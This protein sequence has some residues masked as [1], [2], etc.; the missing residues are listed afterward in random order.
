MQV[1]FL[2][3][4]NFAFRSLVVVVLK[5]IIRVPE[6]RAANIRSITIRSPKLVI[7]R[8]PADH[9]TQACCLGPTLCNFEIGHF[10]HGWDIVAIPDLGVVYDLGA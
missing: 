2:P 6:K 5:V 7:R 9:D 4:L 8:A 3:F 10:Y 1:D